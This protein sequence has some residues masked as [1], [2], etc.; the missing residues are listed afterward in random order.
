MAG[1]YVR[2]GSSNRLAD[3]A[4]IAEMRRFASGE[5]FDEGPLPALDSEAID[6]RAAAE[7]RQRCSRVAV[8]SGGS[9]PGAGEKT[10]APSVPARVDRYLALVIE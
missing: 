4:L 5:T 8:S 1:C 6:F 9:G 2:V 3:A 7:F 10:S